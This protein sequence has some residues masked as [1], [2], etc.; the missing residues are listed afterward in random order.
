[1]T[2]DT[3]GGVWQYAIDLCAGLLSRNIS[4]VLVAMG[5]APSCAQRG[6]LALCTGIAFYHRPYKL[7][8]MEDPWHDVAAAGEWIQG[9]AA[10]E[11]PDLLHFNNYPQVC[12]GW[13]LPTLLVA[14]SCVATWWHAVR[15]TP[16]PKK[17]HRYFRTVQQAF[18]CADVV[19]SPSEAMLRLYEKTYGHLGQCQVVYNGMEPPAQRGGITKRPII[20]GMGRLWDEAKNVDLILRAACR[21]HGDIFLAGDSADGAAPS[22]ANVHFLGRLSRKEIFEWLGQSALYLLPVRYEPFGLS[23]L[24]A[25]HHRCALVGGDIEVTREL[26]ADAMCYVD[27]DDAEALAA[28]CN[29]LL[30]DRDQCRQMGA[31]AQAKARQYTLEKKIN[32]YKAVYESMLQHEPASS[33]L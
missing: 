32:S 23:F 12:L 4:V 26:W 2:T 21:I 3:V 15:K 20:F 22:S 31:L 28:A 29:A 14:H 30:R 25:A 27:T 19:V 8:W 24:E 13:Q 18:R 9:I 1:M 16:L 7:E 17:Y 33:S 5:P 10:R 11:K 6:Q